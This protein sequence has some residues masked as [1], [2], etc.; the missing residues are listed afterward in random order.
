MV[1]ITVVLAGVLYVWVM[2]LADTGDTVQEIWVATPADG[3][4]PTDGTIDD[5]VL[6]T[7]TLGGADNYELA[8]Y[9]FFCGPEN[10]LKKLDLAKI[11]WNLSGDSGLGEDDSKLISPGETIGWNVSA[12]KTMTGGT[13]VNDL[14]AEMKIFIQVRSIQGNAVVY[15]GNFKY[16]VD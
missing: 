1:A 4:I 15:D 9:A 6:F 14:T 7:L 3:D 8:N 2:N 13:W 16:A 10:Q 11:D 5:E 12:I